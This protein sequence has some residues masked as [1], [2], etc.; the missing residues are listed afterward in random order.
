VAQHTRMPDGDSRHG[1]SRTTQFSAAWLWMTVLLLV[2]GLAIRRPV[3]FVVA[4]CLVTVVPVAWLWKRW[5]L[6]R[7]EYGRSFDK[8]RAFPDETIRVVIQITNRKLL[9]VTWLETTDQVP[10]ALP[11]V[12]GQLESTL[13][14]SVGVIR[15]VLAL[16]WHERFTRRYELSCSARGCYRL[17]PVHLRSGDLFTLFEEQGIARASDRLVVYPRTWPLAELGLRRSRSAPTRRTGG[18]WKTRCAR[19]GSVSTILRTPCGGS[20]GRRPPIVGSCRC[21]STSRPRRQ[22]SLSC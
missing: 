5:S 22:R 11:L 8:L 1:G 20:T 2:A 15:N 7:L 12:R 18:C 13:E 3:L 19:W 17:G 9:P 10:H 21:A 16:R 4:A 14:P 6:R